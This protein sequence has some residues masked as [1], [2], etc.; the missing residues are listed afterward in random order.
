MSQNTTEIIEKLKSLTLLEAA[1]LVSE[2][3]EIFG[4]DTSA[5][6]SSGV[7]MAVPGTPGGSSEEVV[8]EKTTFAIIIEAVPDEKRV[9]VLKV[10]R[11]LTSLGLREAKEL[12]TGLPKTLNESASKEDA[13]EAKQKLEEAGATVKID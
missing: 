8:E 12:T 2:I 7:M 11:S 3:E 5:A 13:A 9:A 6:V 10:I 4:V 1:E